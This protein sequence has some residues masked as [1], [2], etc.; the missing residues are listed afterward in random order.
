MSD[1]AGDTVQVKPAA[2]KEM[3]RLPAKT[4]DRV[5]FAILSLEGNPRPR[6]CKKLRGVDEYRLRV[7]DYRI[8]YT[9][10]DTNRLSQK[11]SKQL[12]DQ[13]G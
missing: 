7:G 12:G 3:D 10:D 8:L 13:D 1:R 9:I 6:L 5:A 2:E 11:L 4:F